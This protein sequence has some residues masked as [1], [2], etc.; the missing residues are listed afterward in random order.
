M[1]HLIAGVDRNNIVREITADEYG[2]MVTIGEPHDRVHNGEQ[3]TINRLNIAN[4]NNG[5][6]W[7]RIRTG[8]LPAHIGITF[9]NGGDG[10]FKTW[11]G[12]TNYATNGT[13]ADG[14]NMTLF[15]RNI[16]EAVPLLS[17]VTF[18]PT[19]LVANT[20]N[21]T[22][23][24]LRG[25]PGGTGG[26]ATGNTQGAGELESIIP[27]NSDFLCALQN[28]SGQT[29]ISEIVIEIYEED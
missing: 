18:D 5:Y 7:V 8:T 9:T 6:I 24:G 16:A 15:N 11:A 26:T 28:I 20:P 2:H 4:A 3:W 19:F 25:I 12:T 23:R 27:P 17:T 29:R 10:V 22:P 21:G 13:D 1:T 14:V